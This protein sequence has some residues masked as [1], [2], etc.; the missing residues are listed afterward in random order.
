[1]AKYDTSLF[2]PTSLDEMKRLGWEQ[3]DV[4]LFSG[5]AYV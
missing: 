1:M 2:L 3:A 4:I 5:D